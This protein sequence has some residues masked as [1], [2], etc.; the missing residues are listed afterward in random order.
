MKEKEM[1]LIKELRKN[2]RAQ[3][4]EI[5]KNI[6]MPITTVFGKLR[7]FDD[8]ILRNAT[9]YDYSKISY[10]LTILYAFRIN[11]SKREKTIKTISESPNANNIFRISGAYN[12]LV[13][14]IFKNLNEA[15]KF[16]ENINSFQPSKK[17]E[18]QVISEIK[19]EEFFSA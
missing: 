17:I 5:S 19:K 6:D 13:E 18:Y 11:D 9:L 14:A 16:S 8:I 4:T 7:R 10:P 15:Y 3:L 12:I 1:E 2:S